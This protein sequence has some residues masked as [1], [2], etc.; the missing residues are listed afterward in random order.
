MRPA[1][2]TRVTFSGNRFGC[3]V[4]PGRRPRRGDHR[5][6]AGHGDR[7]PRDLRYDVEGRYGGRATVALVGSQRNG[8]T[9]IQVETL[10]MIGERQP[11]H[12]PTPQH[13]WTITIEGTPSVQAHVVTLASFVRDVPLS[14]HVQSASVA[15]AMQAVN[16]VPAVCAAAPGFVTMA[17]I[18]F[19][20]NRHIA[21]SR[22]EIPAGS[23]LFDRPR[24]PVTG[25]VGSTAMAGPGD[26]VCYRDRPARVVDRDDQSGCGARRKSTGDAPLR[27]D[28]VRPSAR[29]RSVCHRRTPT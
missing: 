11:K 17:D 10:W 15:T 16:A 28:L 20:W 29:R 8:Q 3:S 22:I 6:G 14:D 4:T 19:V 7:G 2:G 25:S 12:W 9:V 23:S 1:C 18:P 21:G 27:A 13:G 26:T 5:P 24:K